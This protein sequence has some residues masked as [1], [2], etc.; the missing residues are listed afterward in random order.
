M[1]SLAVQVSRKVQKLPYDNEKRLS[2]II[3]TAFH[4]TLLHLHIVATICGVLK[5][6]DPYGV[7]L[8]HIV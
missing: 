2:S 8:P 7:V 6:L 4:V 3:F 5:S 1:E